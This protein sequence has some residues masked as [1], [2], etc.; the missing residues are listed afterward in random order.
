MSIKDRAVR[1]AWELARDTDE[2][3]AALLAMM[4][5]D[6]ALYH[7]IVTPASAAAAARGA[8]GEYRRQQRSRMFSAEFRR[9]AGPDHRVAM[10]ARTNAETLFDMRL[11]SGI[12]LG[13]ATRS[14]LNDAVDTYL[15]QIAVLKRRWVFFGSVAKRVKEGQ[16]VREVWTEAELE[17]LMDSMDAV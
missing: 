5:D 17:K 15:T 9:P 3:V 1:A 7:E 4:V 6:P 12:R 11:P 13:D 14:D 2:A 10:L 8:I 16:S